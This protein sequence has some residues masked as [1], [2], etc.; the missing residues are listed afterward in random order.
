LQLRKLNGIEC[1]YVFYFS[2]I[3]IDRKSKKIVI[4]ED[5]MP[6]VFKDELQRII[7]NNS[8][9]FNIKLLKQ[10]KSRI[11]QPFMVYLQDICVTPSEFN[12]I[13]D[14]A[15]NTTAI[16]RRISERLIYEL[17]EFQTSFAMQ[18]T[19]W[20]GDTKVIFLEPC[21]IMYKKP[22]EKH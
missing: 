3:T 12:N 6:V 20:P 17:I 19:K 4:S 14:T 7:N 18:G 9:L 11:I 8:H 10:K 15:M 5:S 1:F 21:Y 2:E 13:K 16:Y 22:R